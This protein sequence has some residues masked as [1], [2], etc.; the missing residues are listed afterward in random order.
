MKKEIYILSAW[1]DVEGKEALLNGVISKLKSLGKTI[2]LASHYAI[3]SYIVEKVDYYIYDA[4]NMMNVDHTLD[5]DGPD[6]WAHFQQFRLEAIVSSH[7]SSLCRILG[8]SMEFIKALGYDYFVFLETDSEFDIEDL[9]KLDNLKYE[10]Q[11]ENKKLFFFKPKRVE[12]CWHDSHVYETYCFGGY[13]AEFDKRLKF[14]IEYEDFRKIVEKTPWAYCFEYLMYTHFKDYEHEYYILGTFKSFLINSKI[15]L[16]TVGDPI[17]LYYNEKN[18]L[19]PYIF[20]YNQGKVPRTYRMILGNITVLHNI[21]LNP[22]QWWMDELDISR[23]AADAYIIV[24]ENG[25][26]IRRFRQ[27]IDKDSVKA[28]NKYK[29]LKFNQS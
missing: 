28:L 2:L 4:N 15:D 29:R 20:I 18:E 12:F 5:R 27:T 17:G 1:P 21:T 11:K 6:Y 7:T 22:Y 24:E 23:Y 14:P 16:F 3:P 26:T 10:V 13:V 19:R 25:K 8:I 9:K